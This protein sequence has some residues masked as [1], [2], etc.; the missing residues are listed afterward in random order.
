MNA[1]KNL[2]MKKTDCTTSEKSI[3][4][5]LSAENRKICVTR[6]KQ[7]CHF[8]STRADVDTI[9]QL[10]SSDSKC[11]VPVMEDPLQTIKSIIVNPKHTEDSQAL[12]IR[13]NRASIC[14]FKQYGCTLEI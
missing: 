10:L 4:K 1:V 7:L 5:R 3:K 13:Y 9:Q 6:S 11:N 12:A 8:S 14:S 2:F